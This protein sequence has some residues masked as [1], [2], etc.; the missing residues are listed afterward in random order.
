MFKTE[1]WFPP[2]PGSISLF[3]IT[4]ESWFYIYDE[5]YEEATTETRNA[6]EENMVCVGNVH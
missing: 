4:G 3:P 2:D 5:R 1:P 6:D